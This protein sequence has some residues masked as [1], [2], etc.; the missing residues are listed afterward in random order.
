VKATGSE[1][2]IHPIGHDQPRHRVMCPLR[3]PREV[4]P[5]RQHDLRNQQEDRRGDLATDGLLERP[6]TRLVDIGV[7]MRFT[8]CGCGWF[9]LSRQ[10]GGEHD[11][12]SSSFSWI[13][14]GKT[15]WTRAAFRAKLSNDG[16]SSG[17]GAGRLSSV[18][19][20]DK[21]SGSPVRSLP[22][23]SVRGPE[24]ILVVSFVWPEPTNTRSLAHCRNRP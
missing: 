8:G 3:I 22:E 4:Q 17:C 7:A 2:A 21:S 18:R 9:G 11:R 10:P 24:A 19:D 6:S 13:C 12:R 23:I 20:F 15:A 16:S 14:P 1:P 5:L